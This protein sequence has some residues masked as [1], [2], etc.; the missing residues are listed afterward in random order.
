MSTPINSPPRIRFL[1]P[2]NLSS[3]TFTVE[4]HLPCFKSES[5]I[6]EAAYTKNIFSLDIRNS[7]DDAKRMKP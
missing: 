3:N 7:E 4:E 6:D 2:Q 1:A 5:K